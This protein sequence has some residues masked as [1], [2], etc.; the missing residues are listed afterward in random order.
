MKSFPFPFKNA[1]AKQ[2]ASLYVEA[3]KD[4]K[5][6]EQDYPKRFDKVRQL[7]EKYFLTYSIEVDCGFTPYIRFRDQLFQGPLEPFCFLEYSREFSKESGKRVFDWFLEADATI[8]RVRKEKELEEKTAKEAWD[9]LT[10]EQ[11]LAIQAQYNTL[12]KVSK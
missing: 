12:S 3:Y 5:K 4:R 10:R 6:F 8:E 9:S 1:K 7:A 2:A 11:K